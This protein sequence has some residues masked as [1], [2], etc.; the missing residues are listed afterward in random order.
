MLMFLFFTFS[1]ETHDP[2]RDPIPSTP[3]PVNNDVRAELVGNNRQVVPNVAV[4]PQPPLY[5]DN[6]NHGS[7]SNSDSDSS[8]ESVS[9]SESSSN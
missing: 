7:A 4:L 6:L 9:E 3:P 2:V 1:R 5:A 8:L